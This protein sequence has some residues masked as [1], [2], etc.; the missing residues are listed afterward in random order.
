MDL[1]AEP[2]EDFV[3]FALFVKQPGAFTPGSI[4]QQTGIDP[5]LIGLISIQRDHIVI[6]VHKT[7]KKDVRAR[8]VELGACKL[9]VDRE[10]RWLW[11]YLNLGRNHGLT[12]RKLR[13]TLEAAEAQPVGR[14]H[15]N[16]NFT[17]V[18]LREDRFEAVSA[19]LA[20]R[21]INGIAVQCREA[22][23]GESRGGDPRYY[24]KDARDERSARVAERRGHGER[25]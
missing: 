6:E 10:L 24:Q 1:P 2:A 16:N 7:A 12:M 9:L 5:D 15:L 4:A 3:R 11:M 13:S 14:I 8:L 21:S 17:V 25:R 19:Q 18:G 23:Q 22:S 20:G